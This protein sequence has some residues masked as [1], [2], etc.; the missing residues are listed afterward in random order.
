MAKYNLPNEEMKRYEVYSG[1]NVKQ[2]SKL[3]ADGRVPASVSQIM[4]RRLNLRNDETGVKTF[5]MDN[6]F[7]TGDAVVYHPNGDVKVVLDSQHLREMTPD[8]PRNSGALIIGEDVYK[9]LQGEE[10][11]KGKLGKTSDWL[12]AK[13]AK[14]HPVW[15]TLARDQALLDDYVDYIFAEGKQRFNY[16]TDMGVFPSSAQGNTPEMRAWFV[17]RLEGGSGVD[18]GIDLGDGGGRLLGIAPEAPNALGNGTNVRT[19]TMADVQKFGSAVDRLKEV[20][21]PKLLE[22]I[23]VMQKKL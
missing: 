19:Y 9:A 12:S 7:D 15:K 14:A 8:T 17:V 18:G 5:Y 23:L 6:Y 20:V 21:N 10:F 11:K 3:V 16:D 22:D 4:Q 13:E 1:S 2:M